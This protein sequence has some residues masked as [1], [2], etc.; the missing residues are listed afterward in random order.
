MSRLDF[1]RKL[2]QKTPSFRPDPVNCIATLPFDKGFD[3]SL[4]SAAALAEFWKKFE[5]AKTQFAAFTVE[6][7]TDNSLKAVIV[8][9]F[10]E[11]V[12]APDLCMW[13]GRFC[14]VKGQAMKVRDEDGICNCAW[15]V[16]VQQ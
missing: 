2:V 7:L 6:K 4:V 16:P 3:V 9:M 11:M 14:T 1:S 13:L 15:R 12:D 8:R 10:N 5:M